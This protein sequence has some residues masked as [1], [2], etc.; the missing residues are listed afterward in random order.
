MHPS[1]HMHIYT[2]TQGTDTSTDTGACTDTC[3]GADT[4]RNTHRHMYRRMYRHADT[5]ANTQTTQ[6]TTTN[7]EKLMDGKNSYSVRLVSVLRRGYV[8]KNALAN[9]HATWA[10]ASPLIRL[11]RSAAEGAAR[12][13]LLLR[14]G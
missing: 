2:K 7:V 10:A 5:H 9:R 6:T 1:T 13:Y 4:C 11:A 14:Q 8:Q 3:T 12:R